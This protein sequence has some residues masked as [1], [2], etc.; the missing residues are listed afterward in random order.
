MSVTATQEAAEVMTAPLVMV[1]GHNLLWRAA[2][3]FPGRITTRA[4]DDRTGV[5]G[6][7]ALLRAG[8]REVALTR[9]VGSASTANTERRSAKRP[10]LITRKT[11][12]SLT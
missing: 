12:S 4:G 2:Y 7:F 11:A 10:I 5:F 3:G 6:F 8:L 1:D 9:S